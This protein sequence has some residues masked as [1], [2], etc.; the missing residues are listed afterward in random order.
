MLTKITSHIRDFE[1]WLYKYFASMVMT[2]GLGEIGF[3]IYFN[4]IHRLH[5]QSG[6]IIRMPELRQ[7]ALTL[8]A[9]LFGLFER[10]G[11]QFDIESENIWNM[12]DTGIALGVCTK[13][14][15]VAHA[16]KKKAYLKSPQNR[17][18]ILII[19]SFAGAGV[20]LLYLVIFK[21]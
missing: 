3:P 11:S 17:K 6:K 15:V 1:K 20:K 5:L 8:F 14:Q 18:R 13:F 12:V 21:G 19:K 4:E 2:N 10:T 7:L 9:G 16:T